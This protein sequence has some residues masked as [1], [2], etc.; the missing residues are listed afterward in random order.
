MSACPHKVVRMN[1]EWV[2]ES[3]LTAVF[4]WGWRCGDYALYRAREAW[5]DYDNY[6][7]I[8][9]D[10]CFV[11]GCA[12][13]FFEIISRLKAD[14]LGC[15]LRTFEKKETRFA[16]GF[17]GEDLWG[18]QFSMVRF[19]AKAV[20]HLF[21][22]RKKYCELDTEEQYFSN[23]EIFS[24]S[25]LKRDGFDVKA[26]E[27]SAPRFFVP[28]GFATNPD[29][30]RSRIEGSGQHNGLIIHPVLLEEAFLDA[31]AARIVRAPWMHRMAVDIKEISPEGMDALGAKLA[32][33]MKRHYHG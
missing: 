6:W 14:A 9:P 21:E 3:G 10:V 32:V 29:R 20:D 27:P 24:F 5:P 22:A 12:P 25:T 15:N 33:E 2:N 7:L 26:I 13:E 23:D 18:A 16:F 30:L 11:G 31:I 8:E 17:P 1:A 4:D 28:N 19:S